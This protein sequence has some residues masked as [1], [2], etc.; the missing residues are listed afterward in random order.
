MD[1]SANDDDTDDGGGKY[2]PI[3]LDDGLSTTEQHFVVKGHSMKTLFVLA[4]GQNDEAGDELVDMDKSNWWT[5]ISRLGA[6]K[7]KFVAPYKL[8]STYYIHSN[9]DG[10][11]V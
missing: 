9:C 8:H 4:L 1:F 10:N 5:W 3:V 7:R 11:S 2:A 6:C